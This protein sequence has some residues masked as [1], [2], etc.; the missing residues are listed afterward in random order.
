MLR[1][2]GRGEGRSGCSP[3]VTQG[4]Q[5]PPHCARPARCKT[6]AGI[7]C[8]QGSKGFNASSVLDTLASLKAAVT[9]D[10]EYGCRALA[11]AM[12]VLGASDCLSSELRQLRERRITK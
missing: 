2:G 10:A 1:C 11:K 9:A 12:L 4:R 6:L 7:L 5:W 8:L 3:T